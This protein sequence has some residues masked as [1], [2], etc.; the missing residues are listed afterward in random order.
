[1]TTPKVLDPARPAGDEMSTPPPEPARPAASTTVDYQQTR[2]VEPSAKLLEKQRVVTALTHNEIGDTFRMLR[3]RVLHRM[4]AHG[5]TTLA[6]TSASRGDGKTMTAVNLAIS[7]AANPSRTVL[8]V[9]LDLR[10]PRVHEQ[11]G[12]PLQPGL[13]DYM[14]SGYWSGTVLLEDCLIHP[15]G[16]DRL[17]VLPAGGQPIL[18]SSDLLASPEMIALAAELKGR[19]PDRIVIYD[20]PPLLASDD[21]IV[22]LKHVDCC[23][24]AVAEGKT[25]KRAFEHALDLLEGCTVLGTVLN[26]SSESPLTPY[27]DY[28]GKR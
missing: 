19:Y 25:R 18:T 15:T 16:I 13:Q 4:D 2:S 27:S 9:D 26:R 14:A 17:V 5:F 1:M 20:L 21:A 22:F 24:L 6:V 12:I 8:L 10:V 23:L 3:T 28:Y 11:F 7:M